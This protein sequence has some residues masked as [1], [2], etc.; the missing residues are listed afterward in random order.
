MRLNLCARKFSAA[1]WLFVIV[2]FSMLG[3]GQV[4]LRLR[5]QC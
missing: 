3:F 1:V 2:A 4:H 5:E